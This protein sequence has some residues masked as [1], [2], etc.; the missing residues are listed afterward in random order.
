MTE[1]MMEVPASDPRAKA[2]A[3]IQERDARRAERIKVGGFRKVDEGDVEVEAATAY[4][5]VIGR[6][7]ENGAKRALEGLRPVAYDA[8]RL[9]RYTAKFADMFVTGALLF[10]PNWIPALNRRLPQVPSGETT[11][12]SIF[13]REGWRR[14]AVITAGVIGMVK[15]RPIEWAA[16]TAVKVSGVVAAETAGLVNKTVDNILGVKKPESVPAS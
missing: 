11:F 7:G 1:G 5:R 15:F 6:F 4:E 12:S 13:T 10:N 16:A 14:P 3:Y 9:Y 2:I 8:A